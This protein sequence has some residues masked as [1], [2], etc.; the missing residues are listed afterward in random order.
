MK[1]VCRSTDSVDDCPQKRRGRR[2][3]GDRD[4]DKWHR[5]QRD[6][7]HGEARCHSQSVTKTDPWRGAGARRRQIRGEARRHGQPV[8][9]KDSLRGT[10]ERRDGDWRLD[11]WRWI[12]L[13][14]SGRAVVG[15]DWKRIRVADERRSR[16]D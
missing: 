2:Q 13:P 6:R 4:R 8:T 11:R 9:E 10:V 3:R 14:R 1:P 7:Y 15:G 16:G 12:R 5:R